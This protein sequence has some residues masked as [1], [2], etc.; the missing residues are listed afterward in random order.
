MDDEE[1]REMK[2]EKRIVEEKIEQAEKSKTYIEFFNPHSETL[3]KNTPASVLCELGIKA[4]A[5]S[6]D[7][8]KDELKAVG[9]L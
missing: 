4:F 1:Q 9:L 7:I 3:M 6:R 8:P 5:G 2:E